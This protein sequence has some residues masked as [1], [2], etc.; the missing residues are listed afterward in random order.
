MGAHELPVRIAVRDPLP[1][2]ALALQSGRDERVRP[3]TT[4]DTV[5]TFDFTVRVDL[6]AD[7]GPPRFH[8][9]FTQG[10]PRER[11][12]YIGVGKRAGQPGSCWDRRAKVPLD[13]ITADQVREVLE[14]GGVLRVS[15]AGRGKDGTPTCAT[16]KLPPDAWAVE[17]G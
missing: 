9:P 6:P 12:V 7:G 5:V 17:R 16:V 2:V 11:F 8:G 10:P 15:F 13:G 1:G 3:A 4:T 14:R